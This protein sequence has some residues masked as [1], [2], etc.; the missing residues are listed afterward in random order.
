MFFLLVL[1]AVSYRMFST[2]TVPA[3]SSSSSFSMY[4]IAP[5]NNHTQ[6]RLQ[7]VFRAI[8]FVASLS[9]KAANTNASLYPSVL[10]R[11]ASYVAIDVRP[12]NNDHLERPLIEID[13]KAL[14]DL[15]RGKTR[16]RLHNYGGAKEL[17]AVLQTNPEAGIS[18]EEDSI[19]Q[20]IE[21]FGTNTYRKPSSKCLLR[22]LLEAFKDSMII[23][24]LA[25]AVLS[26]SFGIKQDGLNEGWYDGASIIVAVILVL[27]V[28]AISNFKQSRPFEKLSN[29]SNTVRVVVV[30][31]GWRQQMPIFRIVV[32]DIVCLK[33]GDQIPAD[34]LLLDG[35]SL[36]VDESSL[37][38]ESEHVQIHE[39]GN[40]ILLSGTKVTNGYGRM[41]VSSL[42]LGRLVCW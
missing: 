35:Y 37:T 1:A 18:S 32:G 9:K 3:Y 13:K 41:L 30:R 34:G 5:K 19:K 24:L 6:K 10:H 27:G 22:F 21:A 33:I 36:K 11:N 20:R 14:A 4:P 17:A 2:G 15:V 26:L 12:T 40:P 16:D 38:G 8:D 39:T 42:L 23:I 28:S 31:D 25:C 7:I 29:E